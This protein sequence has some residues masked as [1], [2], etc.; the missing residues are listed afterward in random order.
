MASWLQDLEDDWVADDQPFAQ[1]QLLPV[2]KQSCETTE[3]TD[4]KPNPP[5]SLIPRPVSQKLRPLPRHLTENR[6]PSRNNIKNVEAGLKLPGACAPQPKVESQPVQQDVSPEGTVQKLNA[7]SRLPILIDKGNEDLFSPMGLES[8]FEPVA[9]E[10]SQLEDST[11][12]SISTEEQ[13]STTSHLRPDTKQDRIISHSVLAPEQESTGPLGR[14][15][16]NS[17]PP[18]FV[19]WRPTE[20]P[21]GSEDSLFQEVWSSSAS[22]EE[23]YLNSVSTSAFSDQSPGLNELLHVTSRSEFSKQMYGDQDYPDSQ[24]FTP[25]HS[26]LSQNDR[27]YFATPDRRIPQRHMAEH[28]SPTTTVGNQKIWS[29]LKLFSSDHNAF[30]KTTI[31]GRMSQLGLVN[32]PYEE[33]RSGVKFQPETSYAS[34]SKRLLDGTPAGSQISPHKTRPREKIRPHSLYPQSPVK[35]SQAKRQKMSVSFGNYMAHNDEQSEFSTATGQGYDDVYSKHP[36]IMEGYTSDDLSELEESMSKLLLEPE[37]NFSRSPHPSFLSDPHSA[38]MRRQ[39]LNSLNVILASKV[40]H[41]MPRK[42]GSMVFDEK[43]QVWRHQHEVVE[44][45]KV[46]TA[47][48]KTLEGVGSNNLPAPVVADDPFYEISDLTASPN[49]LQHPQN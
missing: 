45:K 44:V 1:P 16:W 41:M 49:S 22:K 29:P 40:Q 5:K 8:M 20:S 48:P 30:T 21:R 17:T 10:S 39:S 38:F 18:P 6:S 28:A 7:T 36:S 43:L 37:I 15:T 13:P 32:S 27:I 42:V 12:S 2:R 19:A 46:D 34:G 35:E 4:Q 26:I 47:E 31:H 23:E 24:Q 33:G 14:S 9:L 3:N 25:G 11:S